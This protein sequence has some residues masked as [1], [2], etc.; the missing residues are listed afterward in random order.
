MSHIT[1]QC[2]LIAP[3]E[4]REHL[5][6]L[7]AEHNTPLVNEIIA[8]IKQHP[9]FES[10]KAKGSAPVSTFDKLADNLRSDSRFE[11]HPQRFCASAGRVVYSMFESWLALHKNHFARFK[12]KQRWLSMLKSDDE[13]VE[14]SGCDLHQIYDQAAQML[15]S[16]TKLTS[17]ISSK[18][19]KKT[20][21]QK[22][23]NSKRNNISK[24]L[25]EQYDT[26][27]NALIQAAIIY[28]L[29]NGCKVSDREEDPEKFA[30]KYRKT[31]LQV[32]RLQKQIEANMPKGRDLTGQVWE[33][34]LDVASST[35]PQNEEE[36]KEWQNTLLRNPKRT[37]YPI[38]YRDKEE[39]RWSEIEIQGKA[40]RRG[41]NR[42]SPKKQLCVSFS[43]LGGHSFK[44]SCD[45][46]QLHWFRRFLKDQQTKKNSGRQC[47]SSLFTLRSAQVVWH[48]QEGKGDPWDVHYLHL[49]CTVEPSRWTAE[50]TEQIRQIEKHEVAKQI[51][52]K[53]SKESLTER[54]KENLG[55][56]ESKLR[57]LDYPFDRPSRSLYSSQPNIIA[58]VSMGLQYPATLVILD[59]RT[60]EVLETRT[61][62]ELLGSK[63]EL[64][65][66]RRRQQQNNA[67]LRHKAQKRSAP[68]QIGESNLGEYID[69]LIAKRIVAIAQA[70]KVSSIIIP[71]LAKIREILNCE[72]MARAEQRCPGAIETQ[73]R[74][75]KE[76]RTKIHR[77]SYSRLISNIQVQAKKIGILLE[78]A[79]QPFQGTQEEKAKEL[80]IAAYQSRKV[81]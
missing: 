36:A 44:I 32:E 24:A 31:K 53:K 6:H 42:H 10:W 7:M 57:G 25:Y 55:K 1:I 20:E 76:Y 2:R 78:E 72:V 60:Q 9:D 63:Y 39:L 52:S 41:K 15:E 59:S 79:E 34:T 18:R 61:I 77:W 47:S 4:T 70:Y 64:L 23:N 46:R 81:N 8:Q 26:T 54:Q 40:R 74:Y 22:P 11:K 51:K 27:D 14:S 35:A 62:R 50:G 33:E 28:L 56:L 5:W 49:H 13:L 16:L 66:R 48:E 69:R 17:S 43:G 65:L 58:A 3:P 19:V 45:R 29:K 67:H 21:N 73:K 80:A 71:K 37:P 12:G 68:N 38:F 30:Q 75:A